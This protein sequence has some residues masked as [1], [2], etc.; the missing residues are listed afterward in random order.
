[1]AIIG[2]WLFAF[3]ICCLVPEASVALICKCTMLS[4]LLAGLFLLLGIESGSMYTQWMAT[5]P[6]GTQDLVAQWKADGLWEEGVDQAPGQDGFKGFQLTFPLYV[7]IPW[8]HSVEFMAIVAVVLIVCLWLRSRISARYAIGIFIAM[9]S[10]PCLDMIFHDANFRMGNRT[11]T[12]VSLGL[13]QIPYNG[14]F[15]FALEVVMAY[16]PYRIWRS[17]RGPIIDTTRP[18]DDIAREIATYEKQF[19][20]I[21]ISHNMASWYVL[22]P[23]MAV[24]FYKYA[25]QLQFAT[26][27]AYWSY[28]LFF[29]TFLSWS[30]ALYPIHMLEKLTSPK[31]TQAKEPLLHDS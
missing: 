14:P 6:P 25:P 8:S 3:P 27:N 22:S 16:V 21:A 19:W 5:P 1:M 29:F 24:G 4:D 12:R 26:P 13:W 7:S 11:Q 23:L 15:T 2:H 9:I 17:M 18:D 10:H 20:T 30:A 31:N 28:V